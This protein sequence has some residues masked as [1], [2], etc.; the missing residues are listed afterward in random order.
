MKLK[1]VKALIALWI[2]IALG[3]CSNKEINQPTPLSKVVSQISVEKEWRYSAGTGDDNLILRLEPVFVDDMIYVIDI[4][5][6][7]N[8]IDLQKGKSLWSVDL[9]EKVSAG[10]GVDSSQLYYTSF[11]GELIAISRVDGKEVWREKL[12]SEAVASPVTDANTVYVQTID[13]KV[14]AYSSSNGLKKWRYDSVGPVLSIRGTAKPLVY[15]GN[16]VATFANGEMASV[17]TTSGFLRWKSDIG[18]PQGRTE[19]ERLVDVDGDPKNDGDVI[20]AVAYQG[21]LSAVDINSGRDVWSK[22][23]SS[24]KGVALNT[25]AVFSVNA[26]DEVVAVKSINGNQLWKNDDLKYRRLST[27][28]HINTFIAMADFEGY[29]HF[30]STQTGELV[31]RIRPD[32]DG[33]MSMIAHD[34]LFY[35]YTRD[36]DLYAYK[37][38]SK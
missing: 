27:P 38:S 17:D 16:L 6:E 22:P 31:A 5:G 23:F 7:L 28:V 4:D 3:A 13:G 35:V 25:D 20:F 14:S 34:D 21:K 18:V 37:L 32:R 12:T 2:V 11:Q 8:A 9:D 24:Y 33:V 30:L 36:G 29:I 15:R 10:L 19:L 1:S 26:D